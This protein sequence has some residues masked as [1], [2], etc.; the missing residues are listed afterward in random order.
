MLNIDWV[1]EPYRAYLRKYVERL[2]SLSNV[3]AVLLF[4]SLAEDRVKPFPESD[5]DLLIIAENLP[6]N[7][8]D[9]RLKNLSLKNG[10][11]IFE[12]IWL[13]PRELEDAVK[14]GWG[15]ILD[16]L[17]FGIKLYDPGNIVEEARKQIE[18]Y[19]I[20]IGRIWKRK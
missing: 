3:K 14:G 13:T 15:V 2:I 1:R 19:Y 10:D 18:K 12:D 5:I 11:T 4:G 17:T 16:A 20:R 9:R 6:E 8:I 7:P